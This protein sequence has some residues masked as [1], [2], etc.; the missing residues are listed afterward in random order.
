MQQESKNE[1][2][3]L[4][5]KDAA[6][7]LSV[8]RSTLY[9]MHSSGRLGPMVYKLGRRSL[10]SRKELEAWVDAGMPNRDRWQEAKTNGS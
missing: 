2:L 9:Q 7:I 3:L 1:K 4:C 6:E 5:F 8:S 10:L